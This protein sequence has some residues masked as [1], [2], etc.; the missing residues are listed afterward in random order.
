ML[1]KGLAAIGGDCSMTVITAIYEVAVEHEDEPHRDV[2]KY[3]IRVWMEQ[4]V[5]HRRAEQGAAAAVA[6]E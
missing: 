2:L 1:I 4:R 5:V 6:P 3:A